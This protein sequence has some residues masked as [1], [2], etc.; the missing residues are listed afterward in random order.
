MQK[1]KNLGGNSGVEAFEISTDS[2]TVRFYKSSKL[3]TYSY[4]SAGVEKVEQMKKLAL[5]GHG[6]NEFIYRYARNDY[7][8]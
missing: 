1:Y 4:Q 7:V 6:L 2:I 3:Y 8:K 5:S